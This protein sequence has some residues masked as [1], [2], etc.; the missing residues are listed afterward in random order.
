MIKALKNL[1]LDTTFIKWKKHRNSVNL[2]NIDEYFQFNPS[3]GFR[4]RVEYQEWFAN[5]IDGKFCVFKYKRQVSFSRQED[6]MLFK[7]TFA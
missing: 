7:L 1:W 4:V 5:N 2:D 3:L 6:A